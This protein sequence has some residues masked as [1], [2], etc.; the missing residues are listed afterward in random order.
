[1]V[2]GTSALGLDVSGFYAQK[3]NQKLGATLFA[4]YN[5]G[6][7]YDPADIGFTAIPEFRRFTFNP[8]I[9]WD[10]DEK[11]ALNIGFNSIVEDRIGGDIAFI[12]GDADPSNVFFEENNTIRDIE[13]KGN[14]TLLR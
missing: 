10:V 12:E 3:Y 11:T 6:S 5:L 2:N 1:M 7:P 9:F 8:R 14:V 4:S 13:L